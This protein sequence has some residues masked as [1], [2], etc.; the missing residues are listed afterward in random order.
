VDEHTR[1]EK[2]DAAA[3]EQLKAILRAESGDSRKLLKD[4]SDNPVCSIEVDETVPCIVIRWRQYATS[5]QL[6]FI[7]EQLIRLLGE[8]ALCKVLGD[9]T[10]MLTIH[11]DDQRWIQEHW[12]PRAKAAGLKAAANKRP[13]SYFGQL[14]V[15]NVQRGLRQSLALRSF[16]SMVE[17]RCWLKGVP[18]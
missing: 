5:A 17:A 4:I 7:H 10:E 18:V 15:R 6:R 3:L 11:A 12:L 1:N 14:S 13:A 9:D 2:K 16:D 8:P